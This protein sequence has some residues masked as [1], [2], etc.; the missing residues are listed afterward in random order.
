MTERDDDPPRP[1][2]IRVVTYDGDEFDVADTLT[3]LGLEDGMHQWEVQGPPGLQVGAMRVA[4]LP[5]RTN[6]RFRVGAR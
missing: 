4:E 1:T 6:I 3:Y 5:A 2:G